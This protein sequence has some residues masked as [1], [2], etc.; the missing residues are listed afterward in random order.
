[1]RAEAREVDGL[2]AGS[3]LLL[4]AEADRATVSREVAG[5]SVVHVAAHGFFRPERPTLSSLQLADGCLTLHDVLGLKLAAD[6]VTLA[7]CHSGESRV[8]AGDEV[9]GLARGFLQAGARSV[10]ASHWALDDASARRLMRA[11]YRSYQAG[12]GKAGAL[13]L[14][15]IEV[16]ARD[17]HPYY[18]A[19]FALIGAA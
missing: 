15:M 3:L 17:R 5:R 13:R 9:V 18:W 8:G 12:K 4:G 6:L 10:L 14:A 11:F 7:A 19:P 1:V 16:M 2:L